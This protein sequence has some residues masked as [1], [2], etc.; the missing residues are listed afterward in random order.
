MDK[1][2]TEEDQHEWECQFESTFIAPVLNV[3]MNYSFPLSALTGCVWQ[4]ISERMKKVLNNLTSRGMELL[5][6]YFTVL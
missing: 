2:L 4:N 5:F 3:S 6:L 1:I